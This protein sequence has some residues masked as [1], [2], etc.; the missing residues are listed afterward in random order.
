[1]R[2][3][4]R[5]AVALLCSALAAPPSVAQI[6]IDNKGEDFIIAWLPA[7]A[8]GLVPAIELHLTSD[9]A[10]SV[11]VDYPINSPTFTTTVA[12]GPGAVTI[13]SLPS[14][15]NTGPA[16]AW[17]ADSVMNNCVRAFAD[18]EFV[19]YMISRVTFT[20]D[21]ALCL[22]IETMN[23]E[24]VLV[25]YLPNLGIFPS[26]FVVYAAFDDTTVTITPPIDLAGGHAAGVPFQVTLDRGEGYEGESVSLSGPDGSITGTI[27]QSDKP[28]GVTNGSECVNVPTGF[29]ACDH[30]FEVA[31]PVQTWGQDVLVA[32]LPLRSLGSIYR[33]VASEDGTTVNLDGVF[34]AALD[35]GGFFETGGLTG[36]HRFDADKPIFVCQFMTGQGFGGNGTGDPAMGNMI[37][38]EQFQRAYTFS[39]IGGG[40]FAQNFLTVLANN[41]DLDTI[42]LDGTPIGAGSFT[43][44][45]GSSF[46]V[47]LLPLTEGTHSTASINPHGITVEGYNNFDSYLYPGGASFELINP[48]GDA[49][50][51]LCSIVPD[52]NS[53]T[54]TASDPR[55]SEDVNGNG[56][57]DAGEDL[58]GNGQIDEDTGIF[59]VVL[60]PASVNVSLTVDP[61]VPG[62]A[63]VGFQID[64]VD[65]GQP[66]SATVNIS[67]GAG[68][69]TS[70]SVDFGLGVNSPP[71]FDPPSPCGQTLMASVGVPISFTVA[72]SDPDAGD[73]V[74][75]SA[76]GVPPGATH[77]PPLPAT[78]NPVSST[79]D[80]TPSNAD[81]GQH[82]IT[83][84]AF[85]GE[86][87][88][89]CQVTLIVAECHLVVGR[90][91]GSELF[92]IGGYTFPTQI[93]NIF[94][95]YPV[96]M[97][98]FPSFPLPRPRLRKTM[99]HPTLVDLWDLQVVMYN[100]D[101]FPGNPEQFTRRLTVLFWSN[102]T[103]T[104]R[105]NGAR[106]GMDVWA[107]VYTGANGRKYVRFPFSIDGM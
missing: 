14:T 51:P 18:Q 76:T 13:V 10:T 9:V 62:D 67:D 66:G 85:D 94:A 15:I 8:D 11:T 69:L 38:C 28:V 104:T 65:L 93:R 50:L 90:F 75:L 24:Y 88:A 59:F 20:S 22:P 16:N 4:F 30:V 45:P 80:W 83:Y 19:A 71:V 39:T 57:L 63:S 6:S 33:I 2:S 70:C 54:G 1:M 87:S 7:A 68:N 23:T 21:A 98:D 41:A 64:R 55:P 86:L 44:I 105:L 49:N 99:Q 72:A 42:T 46:S 43:A 40:Q 27:V 37:P 82:V 101:V 32:N 79:F 26:E 31:Q 95:S 47:A 12:V 53:A 61:F 48:A 36:N 103:V 60:D 106:D 56:V 96:T 5:T 17:A 3:I 58:N 100:A 84:T 29:F 35:R 52:V 73:I 78:G 102:N 34:L 97:D 91:A 74:T 92:T 107:D 25:D 81:V 77:T 89:T